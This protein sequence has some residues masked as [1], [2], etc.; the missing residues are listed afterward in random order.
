[1]RRWGSRRVFAP[2]GEGGRVVV[3]VG[4]VEAGS[5]EWVS[6]PIEALGGG[7]GGGV[8]MKGVRVRGDASGVN[9]DGS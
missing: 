4:A 8:G 1:M 6:L 2:V 9:N 7:R 3:D 5:V